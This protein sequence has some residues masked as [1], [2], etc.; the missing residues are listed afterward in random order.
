[1]KTSFVSTSAV[2]QA[3]RYQM[4]R[5]QSDLVKAQTEMSSGSFADAGLQLGSR[6]GQTVSFRRDMDR[7]EAIADANSVATAR[8]AATQNGLSQITSAAQT[9]LST[10]T[11]AVSGDANAK[12]TSADATAAFTSLRDVVNG[13]LNGEYIFAGVSTDVKP[14]A[15]FSDPASTSRMAFDAAF[16][17][18]F[19]F[20]ITDPQAATISAG[21][22]EAFIDGPV[23]DLF[24]GSGW[25]GTSS[26]ASN[27]TITSRITMTDTAQTSLSANAAGIRKLAM[28]TALA[29]ALLEGPLNDSARQL[30]AERGASLVGSAIADIANAQSEIGVTQQRVARANER[31]E[32]QVSLFKTG[33]QELEGVDPYE[34]QTR[35]TNLLTQIETSYALTARIQQLS[36]LNYLP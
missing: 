25:E 3:L 34:A 20:S 30:V 26:F 18:Q 24:L 35:V 1:M 14:L 10:L 6:T 27:Q 32:M 12:I 9:Y 22:L 11:A 23:N 36:L 16:T 2:N 8:M 7:L 4:M 28:S 13:S 33:L 19:G 15:D 5:L 29:Q 21:A 17:A 31:I